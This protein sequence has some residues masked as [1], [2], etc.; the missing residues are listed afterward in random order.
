MDNSERSNS[1]VI[2]ET[3]LHKLRGN[4]GETRMSHYLSG[5]WSKKYF[6]L[7]REGDKPKA[8]YY[9]KKPK[10]FLDSQKGA[11]D[12]DDHYHVDQKPAFKGRQFIC[13]LTT[14]TRSV[15]LAVEK[16]EIYNLLMFFLRT[17]IRLKDEFEEECFIVRPERSEDQR[18]IGAQSSM[19]LLHISQ[20]G[21]TL[22]LQL[23][24][25]VLAQ[26][27]LRCI[28]WYECTGRGRFTIETGSHSSTGAGRYVFK[29]RVGQDSAIYDRIDTLVN[30][31][32]RLQ[33]LVL[34]RVSNASGGLEAFV[35]DY[36]GLDSLTDVVADIRF[37]SH[38]KKISRDIYDQLS[39]H[40]GGGG[41][42]DSYNKNSSV[43]DLLSSQSSDRS[44]NL[45]V[46]QSRG[47]DTPHLEF[48]SLRSNR[49]SDISMTSQYL[50][51]G[52]PVFDMSPINDR[53]PSISRSTNGSGAL[54]E[55]YKA[56][57][58]VD[59]SLEQLIEAPESSGSATVVKSR[60]AG[61]S[62]YKHRYPSSSS[63]RLQ[64]RSLS[65]DDLSE[66]IGASERALSLYTNSVF[67]ES[68]EDG[69][70]GGDMEPKCGDDG[71]PYSY[72][73]T[74]DFGLLRGREDMPTSSEDNDGYCRPKS[75]FVSKTLS[76]PNLLEENGSYRRTRAE[77]EGTNRARIRSIRHVIIGQQRHSKE[78]VGALPLVFNGSVSHGPAVGA[79]ISSQQQMA[80]AE[81]TRP[82]FD[83]SKGIS[84]TSKTRIFT[85]QKSAG[86]QS[87]SPL[88]PLTASVTPLSLCQSAS[89]GPPLMSFHA[90]SQSQGSNRSQRQLPELPMNNS[91]SR[92]PHH[93]TSSRSKDATS[94]V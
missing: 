58:K 21:L 32:T 69:A 85:R 72:A 45:D 88:T 8:F 78:A 18:R 80:A 31:Q 39:E 2:F 1:E 17:Q 64:L 94:F 68:P 23:C 38:L 76:N 62:S 13:H 56:S 52:S 15:L 55:S 24:K 35:L 77:N 22:A 93:S 14:G 36:S 29:T 71:Y 67:Q 70:K 4:V 44:H 37:I 7:L 53:V 48:S 90:L 49:P 60:H 86:I 91:T 34:S 16:E 27:P 65:L 19:C 59:Y 79:S 33:G 83:T 43:V 73:T 84:T 26:W 57:S 5:A 51:M 74:P 89:A 63:T 11:I 30:E 28:R 25:S 46:G 42:M 47:V 54:N 6:I 92:I 41:M 81:T 40:L 20:W 3:W 87:P 82:T 61:A 75:V 9:N 10:N 50:H 12:L 66:Y